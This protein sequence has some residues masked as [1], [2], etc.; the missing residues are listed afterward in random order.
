MGEDAWAEYQQRRNAR[1]AM[2]YFQKNVEKV[3]EWRRNV[4]LKLIAYKGGK[5]I[6]CGYDKPY[7]SCYHF[8]HLDPIIK[9]F[10]ISGKTRS[11][12]RLQTEADKC[13]L[14][15]SRCHGERHDREYE[16][17][18]KAT[19]LRFSQEATVGVLQQTVN[20]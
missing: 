9:E 12:E 15:C 7:P 14:V 17:R 18:R 10:T 5:C 2:N 3:V 19:I 11:F 20:L 8:H 1:K 4:K 16:M 13:I 6:D